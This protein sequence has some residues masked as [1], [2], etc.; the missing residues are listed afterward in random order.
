MALFCFSPYG[1]PVRFGDVDVISAYPSSKNDGRQ[2]VFSAMSPL[3]SASSR[4]LANTMELM[5]SLLAMVRM[6]YA[7]PS[8]SVG[9]NDEFISVTRRD[10]PINRTAAPGVFL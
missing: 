7:R 9:V 10:V 5:P 6:R 4:G 8:I 2:V 3:H 1:P